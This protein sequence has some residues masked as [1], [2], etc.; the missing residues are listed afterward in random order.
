MTVTPTKIIPQKWAG[1]KFNLTNRSQ[2][3]SYDV[4]M[5]VKLNSLISAGSPMDATIGFNPTF[6]FMLARH[7]S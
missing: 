7:V 1:L 5:S 2:N 3:E 4:M 6:H